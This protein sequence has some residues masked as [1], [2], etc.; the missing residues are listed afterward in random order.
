MGVP[1]PIKQ[2]VQ[3][4]KNN[5]STY[6][7][8]GYVEASLRQD[9]LDPFFRALGWDVGNVAGLPEYLREVVIERRVDI[10][11][12]KKAP[13]YA[14]RIGGVTKFLVEAK[15][16]SVAI[17]TDPSPAHQI[18]TYG[19][20]SKV[21]YSILSDFQEFGL[22]DTRVRP[23]AGD[24]ADIARL[25]YL[26][27]DAY[28]DEWDWIA[29]RFSRESV[30]SGVLDRIAS[31]QRV[32]YRTVPV[33][34]AILY[35]IESWR[36]A[37]ASEIHKNHP[38]IS[39]FELGMSVQ[40]LVDRILFLRIC[41][42]R[43]IEP[44]GNLQDISNRKNV[45]AALQDAFDR[46]DERYNSGLFYLRPE[47]GRPGELDTVTPSLIIGDHIL[48]EVI[49]SLYWP[50][51]P[52][53]FRMLGA[54]VLGN[55]YEQFLGRVITLSGADVNVV[56]KP[57]IAKAGGVVYTPEMV[58]SYIL[59]H[60]L[61]TAL[62]GASILGV[63]GQSNAQYRHPLRVLDPACGSGSFLMAAYQHLLDWF[64]SEYS[65]S[66]DRW[67]KGRNPRIF[68]AS[69]GE[70]LLTTSERKRI[71]LDHIYG[72]DIDHQAVEVTKLSLLLKVLENE[73]AESI[74]QQLQ[75][76]YERVLP[77]LGNNIRCGN[78]LVDRRFYGL[79]PR[80]VDDEERA[81]K[82]N[83]FT[84]SDEF[85]AVFNVPRPGFDVV[86][87]NPPYV[88]LQDEFRDE[89]TLNFLKQNYRV[90]AYKID[91][92]HVFMEKAAGLTRRDGYCSLIT[93]SN[94]LTNNYLIDLRRFMLSETQLVEVGVV[95][96]SVFPRRSV[97]CAIYVARVGD[98]GQTTDFALK[99][100]NPDLGGNRLLQT[101]ETSLTGE[102]IRKSSHL[103]FTGGGEAIA[104]GAL[105][106]MRSSAVTLKAVASINFGKQ[107]RNR[108]LFSA[109]VIR[110]D[111][112]STT[113]PENYKRCYTG[114]DVARWRV[115][116]NGLLCL[117][118]RV[119]QSGGC[120]DARRQNATNKLLCRQVGFYP[121]FA[122]DAAG[123]QCLNTMFMIGVT[124]STVSP[125]F[126]L[127]VL[128]STPTRAF[129]LD[130]FWDRRRTF[131]KVKGTYLGQLPLPRRSDLLVEKT[132][133]DITRYVHELAS[134]SSGVRTEQLKRAIVA[135]EE[136]LDRRVAELY[137]MSNLELTALQEL[138][139]QALQRD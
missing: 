109:D 48:R 96:D 99:R 53:N 128:N 11:G 62:H 92:Y 25:N 13:D 59:D 20:N 103:L 23:E 5:Q 127:G 19:W 117:D 3:R 38:S 40:L 33:D 35:A 135:G 12:S 16:P 81:R 87:G 14:F 28:V 82:I 122:I 110:V 116:W 18:R 90:P 86:V 74:N 36:Q 44:E 84:W 68:E 69:R 119:A 98:K 129:W 56:D 50:R 80:L 106:R 67:L 29:E 137:D 111:P 71:L 15:K 65:K 126:L 73:S 60:T 94:W 72:V 113:I 61:G 51:S 93:P 133:Q 77:D 124:D 130:R 101:Q 21:A 95:D 115:T 138:I 108:K 85:P 27:Y 118:D 123:Y 102:I 64:L 66:P 78:S 97:D 136:I 34:D 30:A 112:S 63:T 125:W 46:A 100:L 139:E 58:V 131:P 132:A 76:V 22:Y 4:F 83:P 1:E 6:L 41:E 26:T 134:G 17:A 10:S 121:D 2:L 57:E 52:F 107:L 91:L 75:L 47:R 45:Y 88:L 39:A 104:S 9:F 8:A 32:S 105:D 79:E 24:S 89:N 7:S 42:D 70:F 54:Q 120:W 55:V 37:L 43:G 49:A 114:G 31:D